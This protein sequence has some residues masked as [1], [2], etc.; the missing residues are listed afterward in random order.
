MVNAFFRFFFARRFPRI[1]SVLFSYRRRRIRRLIRFGGGR[2]QEG[3]GKRK[4]FLK[5]DF[6]SLSPSGS[7]R[8]F[9][10]LFKL[11][12]R[13]HPNWPTHRVRTR[14]FEFN[15]R[16]FLDPSQFH[17]AHSPCASL[18]STKRLL[19]VD[20]FSLPFPPPMHPSRPPARY[21]PYIVYRS[22]KDMKL[23]LYH[24]IFC[25]FRHGNLFFFWSY[26]TR[27]TLYFV[28]LINKPYF[29]PNTSLRTFSFNIP[30]LFIYFKAI[31]PMFTTTYNLLNRF[32]AIQHDLYPSKSILYR[33]TRKR[34]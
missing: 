4:I 16:P 14:S 26:N 22:V 34:T 11:G 5:I 32:P 9:F 6:V 7:V 27:V 20:S 31:Y 24:G 21:D 17:L 2:G 23:V 1:F 15:R 33:S 3:P 28:V 8:R 29:T 12:I 18:H 19:G 30:V 10:L 13:S 25:P